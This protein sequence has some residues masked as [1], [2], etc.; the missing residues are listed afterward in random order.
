MHPDPGF[1]VWCF[2]DYKPFNLHSS[3]QR[4]IAMFGRGSNGGLTVLLDGIAPISDRAGL[5]FVY[6]LTPVSGK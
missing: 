1:I 2:P 4:N 3:C 6:L 5:E